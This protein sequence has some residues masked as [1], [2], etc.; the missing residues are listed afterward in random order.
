MAVIT[1]KAVGRQSIYSNKS[2]ILFSDLT[3]YCVTDFGVFQDVIFNCIS[4]NA[5]NLLK[6]CSQLKTRIHGNYIKQLTV[7]EDCLKTNKVNNFTQNYSIE[8]SIRID[9]LL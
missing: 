5:D 7:K 2:V 6:S 1:D 4:N 8:N 9:G 3:V